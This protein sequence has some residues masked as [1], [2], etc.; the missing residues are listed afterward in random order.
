MASQLPALITILT[1]FLLAFVAGN[2]GRARG[3]FGIHAPATTG[4]PDFERVYRVHMNTLENTLLFLPSLWLFAQYVSPLYAGI[5]GAVWILS[6]I[7]YAQAYGSGG[8][9]GPAFG[10][11]LG[12]NAILL[13]GAT[14]GLIKAML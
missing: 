9:R 8:N 12:A 7:W 5:L 4:H 3:K 2:V 13:V 11:S 14:I 10:I 1:L 6:R